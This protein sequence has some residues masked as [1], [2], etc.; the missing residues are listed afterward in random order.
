MKTT[1]DKRRRSER[2]KGLSE[3][4]HAGVAFGASTGED[5]GGRVL[6]AFEAWMEAKHGPTPPRGRPKDWDGIGTLELPVDV[7]A[8]SVRAARG[9]GCR[10]RH[11]NPESLLRHRR[12]VGAGGELGGA[13]LVRAED[14]G[15]GVWVLVASGGED[16]AA[17]AVG[18]WLVAEA[19]K[20]AAASAL[21]RWPASGPSGPP[22]P[23]S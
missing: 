19:P 10:V 1:E 3:A 17:R 21:R 16:A 23:P 11:L 15:R 12:P 8:E 7:R 4:F 20:R 6:E 9:M 18:V 2:R 13:W 22:G 5:A 14:G